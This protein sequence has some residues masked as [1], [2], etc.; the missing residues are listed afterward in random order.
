MKALCTMCVVLFFLI[1]GVGVPQVADAQVGLVPAC[2]LGQAECDDPYAPENYGV[3]EVIVTANNVVS[4]LVGVI[5]IIAAIV[6]VYVGFRFVTSRGNE[7]TITQAR[8]ML[9]NI[10]IGVVIMLSAWLVISTILSVLTGTSEIISK[11]DLLKC[12]Y[13]KDTGEAATTFTS[14]TETVQALIDDESDIVNGGAGTPNLVGGLSND[15][16][17]GAK[18]ACE[19]GLLKEVWGS[20]AGNAQCIARAE[21]ACG[22]TPISVTDVAADGNSFSFGAF[23]INTTVHPV[24]NCGHLGIPDLDCQA[25]WAGG[26]YSATVRNPD[27]YKKCRAAL[28]NTECSMINAKRIYQEA[29]NSWQPWSTKGKCSVR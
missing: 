15:L 19:S 22:A 16:L 7:A 29:G 14:K 10:V 6:I 23:Q 12:T 25:A 18:G 28:L 13:Q 27:L 11:Q 4:F 2:P 26:N 17:E 5:S 21:S 8:Q 1:V 20:Q 24:K 9:T 3:C